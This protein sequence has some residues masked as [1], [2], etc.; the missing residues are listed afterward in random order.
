MRIREIELLTGFIKKRRAA[1]SAIDRWISAAGAADWRNH[2][3]VKQAIPSAS[4]VGR[5]VIFN[6]GG[7]KYRIVTEIDF[8]AGEIKINEVLTHAEYDKIDFDKKCKKARK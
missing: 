8:A 6:A 3:E 7:N 2:A 1:T 5:C 4:F